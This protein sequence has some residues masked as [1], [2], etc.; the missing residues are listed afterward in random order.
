MLVKIPAA[1]RHHFPEVAEVGAYFR[2]AQAA[3]YLSAESLAVIFA[4]L[5]QLSRSVVAVY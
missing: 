5:P 3:G 2:V 4:V 1:G